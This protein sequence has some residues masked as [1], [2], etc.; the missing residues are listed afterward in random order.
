MPIRA[1]NGEHDVLAFEYDHASWEELKLNH[2]NLELLMPC[3]GSKATPKTS[4][5]GNYFFSHAAKGECLSEAE[6]QEHIYIKGLVAKAAKQSGWDVKTEWQGVSS[7]GEAWIADVFCAKGN[8]DIAFEIQLS[9][10][11]KAETLARQKRYK[12]SKVRCAWIASKSVFDSNYISPNKETPFFLIDK[13]VVGKDPHIE[14]FSIQL[15]S[16]IKKMLLGSLKWTEEPWVYR[17]EYIEDK[18]WNCHK[19]NKQVYGY[20]IDWFDETAKTV[21]NAS[22][23]LEK[24]TGII[25]NSE[26]S[27]LGLNAIAAFDNLKGNAPKFPY[28]NTCLHCHAPQNNYYLMQKIQASYKDKNIKTGTVEYSSKKETSGEWVLNG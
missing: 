22:T 9:R 6:S 11:T 8:A 15:S 21:P 28:C 13:P 24:I 25:D 19:P 20:G 17:I 7:A 2:K 3:C 27:V 4:K 12:E 26:L 18:C 23:V 10:Q 1:R 16:F 5:L 14:Q